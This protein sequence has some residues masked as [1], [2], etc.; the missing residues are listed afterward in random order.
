MTLRE[1]I[2]SGQRG[3][4]AKALL[5]A[6]D[7]GSIMDLMF[8]FGKADDAN[9]ALIETTF[10]EAKHIFEVLWNRW[11]CRINNGICSVFPGLVLRLHEDL[12]NPHTVDLRTGRLGDQAAAAAAT[13][14]APE[15]TRARE[16]G[17]STVR[18]GSDPAQLER[19][20]AAADP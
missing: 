6:Y 5:R 11:P 7:S 18:A 15:G 12:E 17:V 20:G 3:D 16:G 4:F 9:Q 14:S 10:P 1:C 13:P 8:A 2:E 19:V